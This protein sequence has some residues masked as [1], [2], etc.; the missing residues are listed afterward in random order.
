M[1]AMISS[2]FYD[3]LYY[4]LVA[5]LTPVK[6]TTTGATRERSERVAKKNYCGTNLTVFVLNVGHCVTV[7]H[8][9]ASIADITALC[10]LSEAKP[11]KK[12]FFG[13]I[14]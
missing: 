2:I 13:I 8:N 14:N 5:H 10:R 3:E 1:Y 6:Y 11:A 4:R 12:F 7:E 9:H